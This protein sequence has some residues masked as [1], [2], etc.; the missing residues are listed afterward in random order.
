MAVAPSRT[1][2]GVFGMVRMT[3]VPGLS[4]AS[5]AAIGMPAAIET[6]S[7]S[8][9]TRSEIWSSTRRMICGFTA[10]TTISERSTTSRFEVVTWM[11]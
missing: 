1:S 8:G 3:R 10:R 5:M 2:A 4:R 6:T 9:R 11:P 7:A